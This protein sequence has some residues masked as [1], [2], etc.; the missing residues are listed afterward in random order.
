VSC[1]ASAANCTGTLRLRT[2]KGGKLGGHATHFTLAH[3]ASTTL[4]V[5][6]PRGTQRLADRRHHLN[7]VAAAST[8]A[9]GSVAQSSRRLTLLFGSLPARRSS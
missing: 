6:L 2:A 3:G 1:P 4:K 8:G 5:K 7:V 9:P